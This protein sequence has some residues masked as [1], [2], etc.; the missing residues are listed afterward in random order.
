[1]SSPTTRNIACPV[2]TQN[3]YGEYANAFRVMVDGA[4]VILDFCVYSEQNHRAQVVSR[5]RVPPTFLQVILSRLQNAVEV[6]DPST[7]F[8][9]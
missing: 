6:S 5:V 2:E 9:E 8:I 7:I 1:M 4:E 3:T